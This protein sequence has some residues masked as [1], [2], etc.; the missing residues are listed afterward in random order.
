M[1]DFN[2]INFK[3][4]NN[5]NHIPEQEQY[6]APRDNTR[7][8]INFKLPAI[9]T[10]ENI[11]EILQNKY[12]MQQEDPVKL[13][14][15]KAIKE[16]LPDA[17]DKFID[18]IYDTAR[19]LK[20]DPLD[21]AALLFKES[22]FNPKEGKGSYKGIGQ[23]NQKSLNESIKYA[24]K[25]PQEAEGIEPDMTI[26]K[27]AKLSREEQMP[28]VKNYALSMKE[29]YLGKDKAITGG[30][31]YALFYTPGF[32]KKHVLTSKDS[33]NKRIIEM[34]EK[35]KGLD[36][37][38][39]N[40]NYRKDGKITKDDLQFTLDSIKTEVFK[41]PEKIVKNKDCKTWID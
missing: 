39:D 41:I 6:I 16:V 21:T 2:D 19:K 25:Y 28:Y 32:A 10:K 17:S 36:K 8:V 9:K 24:I 35:N 7:V 12:N 3:P 22:R 34:Y 11:K 38:D 15:R 30:D 26:A 4:Q 40:N 31:L 14:L 20:C 27:Y 23:M 1:V 29:T 37:I 18:Q 5:I 33:K 13:Q